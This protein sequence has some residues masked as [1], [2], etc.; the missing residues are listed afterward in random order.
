MNIYSPKD[1]A[2]LCEKHGFSFK[3]Q[4]GQNFLINEKIPE[5]IALASAGIE[6]ANG[7]PSEKLDACCVEIGP[8]I[9]SL[10]TKLCGIYKKV[11]SIEV[12][13]GLKD[14]L[15]DVLSP[16]DNV[17]V[18]YADALKTDIAKLVSEEFGNERTVFCSNL[19]YSVTSEA[20]LHI[21]ESGCFDDTVVM[22]QKE[23]AKRLCASPGDADYGSVTAA[24]SYYAK[25]K[26]LFDV[27]A[28][29][30]M[31]R[32]KVTSSVIRMTPYKE[33]PVTPKDEKLFFEL[34]RASFA[35][36]RK[37]LINSMTSYFG[38]R[39]RKEELLSVL[40][41]A[42]IASERRG[43]TL[44]LSEIDAICSVLG[45]EYGRK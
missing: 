11:I 43:E 4:Y 37:T 7:M 20:I 18:V 41:K 12:D 15:S 22:I 25:I 33:A 5:R 38:D 29:N 19:P 44:S 3:K 6:A 42:G 21:L 14:M 13:E 32:P 40:E 10:T 1:I 26:M 36:R 17:K 35:Q 31:P 2:A 23:V 30:F 16:Y 34:I 28:G 27:G 9:G 24:A 39:F 8:G 45:E